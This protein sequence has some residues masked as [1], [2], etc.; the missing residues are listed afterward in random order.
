MSSQQIIIVKR[1]VATCGHSISASCLWPASAVWNLNEI[2]NPACFVHE[3]SSGPSRRP[4]GLLCTSP[5]SG[6]VWLRNGDM[7]RVQR[8]PSLC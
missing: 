8:G 6:V 5:L 4:K 3:R 2:T 1:P 7:T